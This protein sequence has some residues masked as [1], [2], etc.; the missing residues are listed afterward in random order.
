MTLPTDN[1]S[2][3]NAIMVTVSTSNKSRRWPLMIDP[4][5]QALKWIQKME[6]KSGLKTI[7]LS[8]P[9][10]IRTMEQAIRNGT[11]VLVEDVGETLDPALEPILLKQVYV[12]D[13]RTLIN[14]GGSG[15]AIDYDPMFRFYLTTKIANPKYLPDICIKVSLINFTVTMQGLEEQMLGDVVAIEKAELEET[16]NKII[17]SVASDKKRLKQY[18]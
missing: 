2:L 10:Y 13:G 12:A 8:E 11:P 15:N 7:K 16:K 5:G 17:Q 3:E 6:A 4:Q 9:G 18:E 14:F 1:T